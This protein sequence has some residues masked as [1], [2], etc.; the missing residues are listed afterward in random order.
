MTDGSNGYHIANYYIDFV[1]QEND[2]TETWKE[3]KGFETDV[4]RMKWKLTEALYG[5]REEAAYLQ[6]YP[7]E[8]GISPQAALTVRLGDDMAHPFGPGKLYEA[9]EVEANR[10]FTG[11]MASEQKQCLCKCAYAKCGQFSC[12]QSR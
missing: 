12:W 10:L 11:L 2:G 4:W 1:I 7:P 8:V 6:Q 3:V 5:D 9:V